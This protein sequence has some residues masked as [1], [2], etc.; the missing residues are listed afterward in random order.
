MSLRCVC[1]WLCVQLRQHRVAR[2]I[3]K[4]AAACWLLPSSHLKAA[5][6]NLIC[7]TAVYLLLRWR[8]EACRGSSRPRRRKHLL[9]QSTRQ[10]TACHILFHVQLF[11]LFCILNVVNAKFSEWIVRLTETIKEIH[12]MRTQNQGVHVGVIVVLLSLDGR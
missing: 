1:V 9:Q 6:Q 5:Q 2:R 7:I 12:I 11:L 4:T 3:S 10:L 8:M